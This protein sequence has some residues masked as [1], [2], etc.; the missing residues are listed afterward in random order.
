MASCV[1]VLSG[2]LDSAVLLAQLLAEGHTVTA[3]SVD[4][5]QRHHRE[6]AHAARLATHY[7]VEWRCVDL[8]ALGPTLLAGSSQTSPDRIPVPHG[9][10][11]AESMKLT[12]VPN[13]NMLLLALAGAWAISRTAEAIAYAAHAGDHAIYP[14]C[15]PEFVAAVALA[16]QLADDHRV[17]LWRPFLR[18]TK[19]D[20]CRR[21]AVL[22]VPFIETY[23]CYEGAAEHCG[24]CGTCVER[25]EAFLLA[26]VVDPTTYRA[27]A[28]T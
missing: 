22:G 1:L 10:Y 14:D 3:L 5:G 19:A 20:I 12:V 6:L 27:G 11:T 18:W 16:L 24:V 13:R 26:G 28:L 17:D 2:G 21:G 9:H 8:R 7:D 23:S 25:R 15:R 4:Y